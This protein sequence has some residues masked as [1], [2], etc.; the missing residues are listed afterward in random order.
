MVTK[1]TKSSFFL[2]R[3]RE[4]EEQT[5]IVSQV[6]VA[7][8]NNRETIAEQLGEELVEKLKSSFFSF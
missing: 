5:K 3:S 8:A 4:D 7:I 6:Y 2:F 1:L